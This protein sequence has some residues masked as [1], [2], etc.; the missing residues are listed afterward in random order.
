[1]QQYVDEIIAV[2]LQLIGRIRKFLFFGFKK[3][4]KKEKEEQQII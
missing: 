1:L 4:K 3:K 2:N